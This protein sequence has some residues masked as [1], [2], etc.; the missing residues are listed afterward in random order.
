MTKQL[1]KTTSPSPCPILVEC[2]RIDEVQALPVTDFP[3]SDHGVAE[4]ALIQFA[5]QSA[6][7]GRSLVATRS[8]GSSSF[9]VTP[10]TDRASFS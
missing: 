6:W 2:L 5:K 9:H 3:E 8:T 7:R 10:L 1:W 4:A